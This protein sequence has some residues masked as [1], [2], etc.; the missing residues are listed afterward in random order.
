[1]LHGQPCRP[2]IIALYCLPLPFVQTIA[3]ASDLLDKFMHFDTEV[4][5]SLDQLTATFFRRHRPH[6]YLGMHKI[7]RSRLQADCA[8]V[9]LSNFLD[10]R[11]NMEPEEILVKPEP[12]S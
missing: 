4:A 7:T 12:T 10:L 11:H 2:I 1:L 9:A 6:L 3:H 5:Q 8:L